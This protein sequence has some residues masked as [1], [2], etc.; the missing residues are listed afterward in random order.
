[1]NVRHKLC[2]QP[3]CNL[4]PTYGT[5]GTRVPVA[6]LEH[7]D[8]DMVDLKRARMRMSQA[9]K[10]AMPAAA[11]SSSSGGKV[12][13]K[14]RGKAAPESP[15]VEGGVVAG[16]G[17]APAAP[18]A[19]AVA[20]AESTVA[21][22]T[23][24]GTKRPRAKATQSLG[25]NAGIGRKIAEA[26]FTSSQRVEGEEA[27]A[28]E[29]ESEWEE[30]EPEAEAE[31]SGE[32]NDDDDDDDDEMEEEEEERHKR[33]RGQNAPTPAIAEVTS[34]AAA[35]VS[36]LLPA[37]TFPS[38]PLPE[39]TSLSWSC[40]G[41]SKAVGPDD[42]YVLVCCGYG[43]LH[44][45]CTATFVHDQTPCPKCSRLVSSSLQLFV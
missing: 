44:K 13:A 36:P 17:T 14:G 26:I 18:A 11:S 39:G 6:C 37:A 2:R 38:Q 3:K 34:E 42:R 30:D 33:A 5:E 10:A 35:S 12:A 41:C 24:T 8:G 1:M 19:A 21:A 15:A 29:E 32:G 27:A 16:A 43:V 40:G 25:G 23:V 4:V 28:T 22:E 31:A 9:K 20:A 45:A 7:R